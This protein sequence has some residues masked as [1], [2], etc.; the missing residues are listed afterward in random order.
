MFE[1]AISIEELHLTIDTTE[2]DLMGPGF[3]VEGLFLF[4]LGRGVAWRE[5]FHTD[6]RG[7]RAIVGISHLGP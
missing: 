7:D 1:R 5:Y 3:K 6:L 4:D 2:P